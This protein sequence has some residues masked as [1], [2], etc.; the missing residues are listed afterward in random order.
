MSVL[1]GQ[2]AAPPQFSTFSFMNIWFPGLFALPQLGCKAVQFW[3]GCRQLE[4]LFPGLPEHGCLHLTAA[5]RTMPEASSEMPEHKASVFMNLS[6]KEEMS[7]QLQVPQVVLP[8]KN[9]CEKYPPSLDSFC[10]LSL[11]TST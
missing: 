1:Q 5:M 6:C 2:I 10:N 9:H 3:V 7:G 4:L 11:M 8:S